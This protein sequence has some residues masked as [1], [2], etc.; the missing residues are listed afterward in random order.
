M[1]NF[2]E[3]LSVAECRQLIADIEKHID[4]LLKD[5]RRLRD[6]NEDRAER[7]KSN[8]QKR[9]I[10]KLNKFRRIRRKNSDEEVSSNEAVSSYDQVSSDETPGIN[11]EYLDETP[12]NTATE[13]NYFG[14]Y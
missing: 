13:D 2:Y 4:S 8:G 14:Y 5:A 12:Q 1:E 11:D 9:R 10:K 3:R 7:R 6:R